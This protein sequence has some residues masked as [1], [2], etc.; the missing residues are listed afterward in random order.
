MPRRN[1]LTLCALAVLSLACYHRG[2]RNV[3][4]RYFVEGLETIRDQALVAV[5]EQE[6]FD[7]AM[8]GMVDQLDKDSHFLAR[9][10]AEAERSHLDQ[11]FVGLGIALIEDPATGQ[12]VVADTMVGQPRPAHEAGMKPGD[13]IAAIDG[14]SV[15]GLSVRRLTER[16]KGNV[17]KRVEIDVIRP[18]VSEPIRPTTLRS[19]RAWAFNAAS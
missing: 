16:I 8:E 9:K 12:V 1:F 7:S 19:A 6:L 3:Y 5:E 14:K 10:Q 17:D 18:G 2:D 4:G 11:R 15:E 13:R